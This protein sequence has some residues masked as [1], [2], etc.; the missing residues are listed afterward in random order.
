MPER[1]NL[2]RGAFVETVKSVLD[3][4]GSN[5][6]QISPTATVY[7]AIALMAER[8]VG[9][10]PV[11][12]EGKLLGM[13]SERDYARKVILQGRSSQHTMV[14]EIMTRA[15]I[16]VTLEY[17]VDQCMKIMTQSRVRH[18]PVIDGDK[19]VGIVS[20]GDLVKA[21]IATQEFTIDQLRTYITVDYPA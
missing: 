11:V 2:S 5:V 7:E 13:V 20:I 3:S 8:S 9:A 6:W 15:P 12:S 4:K 19:L 16:T 21:I 1:A 18:L 17:T 10:L 14:R